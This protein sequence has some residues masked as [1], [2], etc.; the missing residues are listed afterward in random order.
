[1]GFF[2]LNDLNLPAIPWK[3]YTP[4]VKLDEKKLWTIRS[5]IDRGNDLNLPRLVGKNAL[6]AKK[7]ADD[8]YDK[9]GQK[10]M[11]IYYP[12]F[13]AYKSGTLNVFENKFIIEAVNKDLWNLVTNQDLDVSL[14]YNSNMELI[15]VYGNENFMSEAELKEIC[16][17][18][19]IIKRNFK[20]QLLE[21][22]SILLEWSFACDT[23]INNEPIGNKYLVFYEL[24]TVD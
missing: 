8:L 9:I 7:F 15:N 18:V 6:E 16:S 21:G 17:S 20:N 14:T 2:E 10:G 4:S 12:Y 3:Q 24:R 22:R 1:M 5:A 11:V 13:K 23:D 19:N